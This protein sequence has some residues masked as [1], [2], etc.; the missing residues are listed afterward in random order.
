VIFVD[1][2][3]FAD[4]IFFFCRFFTDILSKMSKKSSGKGS[5]RRLESSST[6]PTQSSL[7]THSTPSPDAVQVVI[8]AHTTPTRTTPTRTTPTRTTPTR[9]TP[10]RTTPIRATMPTLSPG[11]ESPTSSSL[12]LL[13]ER[14]PSLQLP[15]TLAWQVEVASTSEQEQRTQEEKG[16]ILNR[17]CRFIKFL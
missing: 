14:R 17:I 5:Y 16:L 8:S 10:I 9:T 7:D 6:L 2:F 3:F 12:R 15:E 4:I 11:A 13:Q 1:I